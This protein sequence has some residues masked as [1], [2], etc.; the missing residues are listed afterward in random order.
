MKIL[1]S[2]N[3]TK[4][5]SGLAA[6]KDVSL[7]IEKGDIFGL[8]G[9]NG[10]G[11]TTF[12]N[13]ITGVYAPNHGQIKLNGLNITGFSPSDVCR[14]GLSRTF[15]V[16]KPFGE[17]TVVQNVMV[18]TA[19]GSTVQKGAKKALEILDFVGLKEKATSLAGSLTIP[20][21]RRLELAKALSTEPQIILLDEVMAG[22]RPSEVKKTL[23]LLRYINSQGI[24][25]LIIEHIMEAI[26][27]ICNRIA[28]LNYGEKI[29][30]GA[31]NEIATNPE[32][33][34]AYLGDEYVIPAR[35]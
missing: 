1:S 33:I 29:A 17:L 34:A 27:T 12:F 26:M 5:F 24:T 8:I 32:V 14:R 16:P 30:E 13:V 6:L 35:H 28:V 10:S 21:L 2:G 25:L 19:I 18:G 3:C 20:D 15:Q 22:L 11:K 7:E 9:P 31:P 4:Y 23:E